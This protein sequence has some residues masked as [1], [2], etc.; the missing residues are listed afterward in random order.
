MTAD[1]SYKHSELTEAIIGVFYDVY[2]ELGYGFLESVYR[3]SLALALREKGMSVEEERQSLYSF[4]AAM[5]VISGPI[6]WSKAWFW[7]SLRQPTASAPL[8]RRS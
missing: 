8:T 4:A 3:R 2:N 7:L 1:S 6:S 5:L